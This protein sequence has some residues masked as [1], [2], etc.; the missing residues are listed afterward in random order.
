[1]RLSEPRDH[2][3]QMGGAD[4]VGGACEFGF[5]RAGGGGAGGAVGLAFLSAACYG[6]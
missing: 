1:V 6:K 4:A 2:G 3:F 5:D